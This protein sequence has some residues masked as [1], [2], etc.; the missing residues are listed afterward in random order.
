MAA[1]KAFIVLFVFAF[2]EAQLSEAKSDGLAFKAHLFSDVQSLSPALQRNSNSLYFLSQIYASFLRIDQGEILPGLAQGCRYQGSQ[3]LVCTLRSNLKF[4]DGSLMMPEDFRRTFQLLLSP[5]SPSFQADLLFPVKNAQAYFEKKVKWEQVGVEIKKNTLIFNL[6]KP[7]LE[8]I[9]NLTSPLL[10]PQKSHQF[11]TIENGSTLVTSGPY[12]ISET[13]L[14]RFYKLKPNPH[15][16]LKT[17]SKPDVEFLVVPE[18]NQALQLYE[19]GELTFLRRAPTVLIPQL[20]SRKDFY[21]ISQFRF[22]YIGFGPRLKDNENL[23]KAFIYGADYSELQKL[24]SSVKPPGC[25][26]L[27]DKTIGEV[28]FCFSFNPALAKASLEKL[29][30]PKKLEFRLSKL[31]GDDN[32][33]AAEWFQSQWRKNL[34]LTVSVRQVENKTFVSELMKDPPDLFRRGLNPSRP[35]CL[36]VLETFESENPENYIQQK[37]KVYDDLIRKMRLSE[38]ENEKKKLC[39]AALNE[40]TE[41]YRLIP[42]GPIYFSLLVHP[43][44]KGW[45]LNELN[46]LDLTELYVSP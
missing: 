18:D 22:D 25:L 19:K 9:Y 20:K 31:G 2:F 10:A 35:T 12:V 6:E 38:N 32:K 15:F 28:P 14:N 4:S 11:P 44:L 41:N 8:F 16:Y 37:S 7:D 46:Q 33:K 40:L 29:T 36:G 3:K 24:F 23:R 13:K 43:R 34:G 21:A 45:R 39:K 17:Q 42:L 5:E 27:P 1:T 30:A 26:G